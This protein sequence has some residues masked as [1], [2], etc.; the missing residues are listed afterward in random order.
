MHRCRDYFA[1]WIA[2][3]FADYGLVLREHYLSANA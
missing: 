2:M 3:R 1:D